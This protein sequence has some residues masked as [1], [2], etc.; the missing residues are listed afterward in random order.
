MNLEGTLV[1][2]S[3]RLRA[4]SRHKWLPLLVWGGIALAALFGLTQTIAWTEV[5]T[6]LQTADI[7]WI[8][9]AF[10]TLGI[11]QLLKTVRWQML[12]KSHHITPS[13]GELL[14]VQLMGQGLN[15]FLP[16]RIGELARVQWLKSYDRALVLSTITIEKS[17]DLL[18]F[19]AMAVF[20]TLVTTLP[21]WLTDQFRLFAMTTILAMTGVVVVLALSRE[22]WLTQSLGKVTWLHSVVVRYLRFRAGWRQITRPLDALL[23]VG[24]S[25][26]IWGT[27]IFTNICLLAAFGVSISWVSATVLLVVL[28]IGI[29]VVAL[30][31]TI[32]IFEYLCVLILGWF[33]VPEPIA[34]SIG[35]VLHFL[36]LIPSA[37]GIWVARPQNSD[38]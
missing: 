21:V 8:V 37:A 25:G 12:L 38:Q 2:A 24:L 18:C 31:A 27:A 15:T 11:T 4:M 32:G 30:P 7:G 19:G 3:A 33:A 6:A 1:I 23:L 26:L 13:W 17:A 10:A 16:V 35:V 36:V 29:T 28:Q 20:L 14:K 5:R 22:T 9:A 34:F